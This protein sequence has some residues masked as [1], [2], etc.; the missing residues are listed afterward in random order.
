MRDSEVE[1]ERAKMEEGKKRGREK[2][3]RKKRRN[4]GIERK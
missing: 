4:K 1:I 2:K 3:I